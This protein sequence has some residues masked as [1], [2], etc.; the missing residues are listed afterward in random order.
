MDIIK[1]DCKDT[2]LI[3]DGGCHYLEPDNT[4]AAFLAS[5]NRMYYGVKCDIRFT[6]DRVIVTSRYR[7]LKN[8]TNKK[9]HVS[10]SNYNELK[11]VLAENDSIN[12]LTTLDSFLL[13]C[14]KYNKK[15]C[16]EIHPPIGHLEL[17]QLM[18]TITKYG[19]IKHTK[20]ISNDIKYL[21]FIR[22]INFEV[23]LELK[24][25]KFSDD[26]FFNAIKY[27]FDLTLPMKLLSKDLIDMCHD[28]RLKVGS[29]NINDPIGALILGDLK[30]DYIY[31][32]LLEE[33]KPN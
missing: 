32:Y 6:K 33:Y 27:H 2:R 29:W 16:I 4:Y 23:M 14:K 25:S 10:L 7:D 30:V 22:T 26:L 20:I 8:I 11:E 3:S 19:M 21:K 13:L 5:C 28:N 17:Q 18:N 12:T 9:I 24:T 15:A 31:T 1:I